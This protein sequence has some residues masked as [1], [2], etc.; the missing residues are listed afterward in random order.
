VSSAEDNSRFILEINCLWRSA[1]DDA[2]TYRMSKQPMDSTEKKLVA[3]NVA[4]IPGISNYNPF[5][6]N[7]ATFDQPVLEGYWD[8]AKFKALQKANDPNGY[9]AKNSG[10]FHF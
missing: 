1:Q 6:A 7:D 5:F 4:D 3:M 2:E 8:A 9:F 10:G